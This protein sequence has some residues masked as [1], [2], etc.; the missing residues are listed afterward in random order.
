MG[1]VRL[2]ALLALFTFPSFIAMKLGFGFQEALILMVIGL[3]LFGRRLPEML[4]ICFRRKL[5]NHR[6]R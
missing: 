1:M 5:T 4:R 2:V 3:I 6:L